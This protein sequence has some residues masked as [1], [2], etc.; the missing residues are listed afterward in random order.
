MTKKEKT[1][2]NNFEIYIKVHEKFFLQWPQL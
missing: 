2:N 1:R